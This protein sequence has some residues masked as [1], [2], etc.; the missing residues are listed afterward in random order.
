MLDANPIDPI[1]L[2]NAC[3]RFATGVTVVTMLDDE[4]RPTGVTVNS[5]SSLSLDPPLVLFSLGNEQISRRW[6]SEGRHFVVNVLA[7]GQE[8]LA[9]QFAKPL[10]NKFEGIDVAP[11]HVSDVPCIENAIARFECRQYA[12]YPGGDHE[13]FLGEV[14]H[15]EVAEGDPMVFFCGAITQLS[16]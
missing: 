8:N 4:G 6:M 5:F 9:W 7:A 15:L 12:S 13:I 16:R 3:G 14:L 10:D 11:A 2:R 1:E